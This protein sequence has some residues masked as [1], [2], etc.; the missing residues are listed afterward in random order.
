MLL[1]EVENDFYLILVIIALVTFD[2][3]VKI[4]LIMKLISLT[5]F[6]P[7]M[8]L[9]TADSWAI[10]CFLYWLL[11]AEHYWILSKSK[12]MVNSVNFMMKF[13]RLYRV[14]ETISSYVQLYSSDI[15]QKRS[16]GWLLILYSLFSPPKVARFTDMP[17]CFWAQG[18]CVI[19]SLDENWA[20]LPGLVEK[21]AE[22]LSCSLLTKF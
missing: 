14:G 18:G 17:R 8:S 4:C 13:S 2:W 1:K 3:G 16:M 6:D 15:R 10:I 12:Q 9:T 20:S 11:S 5:Y 7:L 22:V 21:V 19:F